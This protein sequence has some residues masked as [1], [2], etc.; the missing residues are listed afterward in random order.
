MDRIL[1]TLQG[2]TLSG[3]IEVV[4]LLVLLLGILILVFLGARVRAGRPYALR[5]LP[6]L[7]ALSGLVGRSAE[8]AR[9]LHISP[10]V[11]GLY[12]QS[13]VETWAGLAAL[14]RLAQEA[15][16]CD[17]PPI[18]TVAD[19]SALPV[20]QEILRL[21]CERL[22]RPDAYD[23]THVRLVAPDPTAYATGVMGMLRR[24]SFS[25]NVMIG[26]FGSEYLL[27][28][29]AGAQEAVPQ[30]AGTTEP[31]TLP[32]MLITADHTLIGEEIFATPAYS[33]RRPFQVGS[34]LAQDWLRWVVVGAIVAGFVAKAL[35]F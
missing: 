35:L 25:G 13:T 32:L 16:A 12:D 18:V 24:E 26:S 27:M 7:E 2:V 15:I 8:M 28:G 9:P 29:E 30:V 22:G 6:G 21:A 1:D 20:A 19:P 3:D 5:S 31:Q 33:T 14:A 34:L 17:T 23:P 4:G 11:R 10:G